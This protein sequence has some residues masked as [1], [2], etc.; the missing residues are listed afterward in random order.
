MWGFLTVS[1]FH[2]CLCSFDRAHKRKHNI[3]SYKSVN[4]TSV[5]L[6]DCPYCEL[7]SINPMVFWWVLMILTKDK[8]GK[9]IQSESDAKVWWKFSNLLL[10]YQT[11]LTG[12]PQRTL[13]P[14][15]LSGK[16]HGNASFSQVLPC[17]NDIGVFPCPGAI[18]TFSLLFII[19]IS[20][21][22]AFWYEAL[23]SM[24]KRS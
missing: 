5:I 8:P 18:I 19:G 23:L 9:K 20:E 24:F 12:I 22:R 4:C 2:V 21:T 6:F 17:N 1:L 3:N 11:V 7:T 10:K 15:F 13:C 16:I 14:N